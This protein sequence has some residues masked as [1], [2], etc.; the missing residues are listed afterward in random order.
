MADKQGERE[1]ERE[2]KMVAYGAESTS[3]PV[4]RHTPARLRHLEPTRAMKAVMNVRRGGT[5]RRRR[6]VACSSRSSLLAAL[7]TASFRR[8]AEEIA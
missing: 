4:A 2:K 3:I 1:R 7:K 6:D 8:C 5:E